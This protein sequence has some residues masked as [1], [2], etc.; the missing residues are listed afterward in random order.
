VIVRW[1]YRQWAQ[2]TGVDQLWIFDTKYYLAMT[3]LM[4]AEALLFLR[5]ARTGGARRVISSIP[6]HLAVIAA[7]AVFV[8]PTAVQIPGYAHLLA[9]L[10]ERLSLGVGVCVCA[11]LAAAEPRRVERYAIAAAA[12]LYFGMVY[13]DERVL[14]AFEDRLQRAVA[15]VPPGDRVISLILGDYGMRANA[16]THMID[17]VCLGRCYSYAN[18][19]P[20]TK[21]FRIQAVAPN[22]IVAADYGDSFRLQT[23]GY[24]VQDADA[25]LHAVDITPEGTMRLV[26]LPTGFKTSVT[27]WDTLEDSPPR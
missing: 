17:R 25:P 4:M 13:R 14:N 6:F 12:L 26:T 23:G 19:E 18:Y 1:S 10:A 11:V 22:R 24:V 20:S 21:Q 3:A 8:L 27:L 5:L 2:S 16:V 7:A 15:P 9:F